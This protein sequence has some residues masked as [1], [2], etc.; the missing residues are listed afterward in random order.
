MV[1]GRL[2]VLTV[3]MLVAVSVAGCCLCCSPPGGSRGSSSDELDPMLAGGWADS[4]SL[5]N[6]YDTSGASVDTS[7]IKSSFRFNDDGT[8]VYSIW[9]ST[10]GLQGVAETRGNY[11]VRDGTIYTYNNRA[12]WE[13]HLGDKNPAYDNKPAD[14]KQYE[15]WFE[16]D[17]K[18][19]VIRENP[20]WPLVYYER[21]D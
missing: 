3:L 17:G 10:I 19:L 15:Y 1:S 7:W 11:R 14:D 12:K 9:G 13:P 20:E 2:L 16:N 5:A 21:S 4:G 18:T 6:I 8:Y